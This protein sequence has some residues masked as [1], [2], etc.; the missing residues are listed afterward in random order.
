M[1]VAE[2]SATGATATRE[3]EVLTDSS[4]GWD[5]A[6]SL[7][8]EEMGTEQVFR[9]RSNPRQHIRKQALRMSNSSDEDIWYFAIIRRRLTSSDA[10]PPLKTCG[11]A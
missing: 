11:I 7:E 5:R 10:L 4:H 8:H 2:V 1:P 3:G 9:I 6:A